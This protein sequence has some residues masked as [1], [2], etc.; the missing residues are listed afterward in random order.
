MDRIYHSQTRIVGVYQCKYSKEPAGLSSLSPCAHPVISSRN[1]HTIAQAFS[2]KLQVR[3][4]L[5][6]TGMNQNRYQSSESR[7]SRNMALRI[8]PLHYTQNEPQLPDPSNQKHAERQKRRQ[9]GHSIQNSEEKLAV[10]SGRLK[11]GMGRCW[12]EE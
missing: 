6:P 10:D 1:S 3:R 11:K 9:Q 7:S 5:S 4:S 2:I 12:F 8:L